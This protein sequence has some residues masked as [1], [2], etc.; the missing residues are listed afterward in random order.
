MQQEQQTLERA[1][2]PVLAKA[3]HAI[4]STSR[5]LKERWT[6]TEK[7]KK[8]ALLWGL[9][10]IAPVCYAICAVAVSTQRNR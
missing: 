6:F 7:P 4:E 5:D 10:Q 1:K 2:T 3:Q 8:L 9:V